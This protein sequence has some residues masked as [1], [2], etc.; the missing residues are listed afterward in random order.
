M[1]S[2]EILS[3]TATELSEKIK[4]KEITVVE[5]TKAVLEQIKKAEPVINSYVTVDEEGALAQA[6][7]VQ[8]KI[9]AGELT[10]PLAG[11]PVAVKDNMLSL[12]HI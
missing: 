10:G 6:E 3:L 4:Q 11:V 2:M 7:E 12:I 1:N 9:D 5:A 8:K